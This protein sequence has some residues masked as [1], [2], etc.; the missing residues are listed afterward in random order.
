MKF[1]LL[2]L[3]ASLTFFSLFSFASPDGQVVK[4]VQSGSIFEKMGIRTGDKVISYDGQNVNSVKD[5]MEMFNK[6]KS[7][8]VKTVV[9][10][11]DG[12]KQTLIF[13]KN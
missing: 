1:N 4:E 6:L 12:K 3:I 11:R 2:V 5:S 9:V 8:L 7:N 10:E 13:Q